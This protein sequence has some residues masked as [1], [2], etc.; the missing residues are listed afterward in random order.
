MTRMTDQRLRGYE[1]LHDPRVNKGTA[2]TDAER[3]AYG[4]EGLL[5]A[6]VTTMEWQIARRHAEQLT[7]EQP[8]QHE[9]EH[10]AEHH[11]GRS[12]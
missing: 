3:R 5:P 12:E 9:R 8:R 11:A 7:L 2:F 4:L 6:G 1:L 10:E